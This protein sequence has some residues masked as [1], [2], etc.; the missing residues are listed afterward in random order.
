[1]SEVAYSRIAIIYALV[2]PRSGEIRY[3]GWTVQ[4]P[5]KRL[6]GHLN[7]HS[8]NHRTNWLNS[9]KSIGDRP[10]LR[11][12]QRLSAS[13]APSSEKY[14]IRHFRE[15]GC[16]LVN[17]TDG[18][19]GSLGVVVSDETRRKLSLAHK[20]RSF[21]PEHS[22]KIS[23][24]LKGR[25][26]TEEHLAK[27]LPHLQSSARRELTARQNRERV[28]TAENRERARQGQLK[29]PPTTDAA[30]RAMS[31]AGKG[32]PKSDA[33]RANISKG[34]T[35]LR[36]SEASKRLRKQRMLERHPREKRG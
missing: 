36:L 3:I 29:R 16:P 6:L 12:I 24:S 35:G 13:E 32:N 11:Q 10:I 8:R 1:M 33:H 19:E 25:K 18:G 27:L 31:I 15:A 4:K 26:F 30:R 21:S 7:D 28:Y 17:S 20:G 5:E 2:D 14:W 23:E 22:R 34:R 9:L